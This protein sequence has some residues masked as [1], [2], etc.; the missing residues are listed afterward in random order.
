ME[1]HFKVHKEKKG[2]WA[3]CIELKGCQT[4]GDSMA[5]LNANMQEA[6]NL[7]LSEN[8]DSQLIFSPP[9]KITGKSI[10][11]I[12]VDPAVA[13]AITIRRTRL[14]KKLTQTQ[15]KDF[16]G[17][18]TLSNYQR[19]EDPKRANPEFRTLIMLNQQI[20]EL[21]IENIFGAYKKRV[22]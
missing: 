15:M 7:F 9:K 4:Q 20:P 1:Y 13:L 3:E 12:E 19:L 10:I 18:K 8:E 6:L 11:A 17:I 5:E 22:S 21:K 16:L 14:K 2:Y